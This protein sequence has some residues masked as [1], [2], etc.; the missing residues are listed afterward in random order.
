MP[1]PNPKEPVSTDLPTMKG[2]TSAQDRG[3]QGSALQPSVGDRSILLPAGRGMPEGKDLDLPCCSSPQ[4]PQSL[5]LS[6]SVLFYLVFGEEL[7]C[8]HP[9]ADSLL[10]GAKRKILFDRK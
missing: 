1:Q 3:K 10:D 2:M 9:F 6:T 5:C 8:Q 4:P 7:H